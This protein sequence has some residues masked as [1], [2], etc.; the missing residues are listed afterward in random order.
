MSKSGKQRGI[1][2]RG[3][4]EVHSTKELNKLAERELRARSRAA[5]PPRAT[6][7]LRTSS[8]SGKSVCG[9]MRR[10]QSQQRGRPGRAMSHPCPWTGF[11]ADDFAGVAWISG[12]LGLGYSL[13]PFH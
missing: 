8:G 12:Q 11:G 13:I 2:F 10:L 6:S 9:P 4:R 1:I 5:N 7:L 3:C